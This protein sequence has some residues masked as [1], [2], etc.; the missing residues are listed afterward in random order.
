MKY[1]SGSDFIVKTKSLPIKYIA[2]L[3]YFKALISINF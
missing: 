1:L 3:V 2:V